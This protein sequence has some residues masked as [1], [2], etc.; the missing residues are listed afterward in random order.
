[1]NIGQY[2]NS[3][4]GVE[5]GVVHEVQ[6]SIRVGTQKLPRGSRREPRH[7]PQHHNTTPRNSLEGVEGSSI[8][9]HARRGSGVSARNSLEG[10]EGFSDIL[11][12][13]LGKIP[14][15]PETP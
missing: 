15:R 4:E 3:L 12:P 8:K 7:E 6:W 5:G 2:R 11:C 14:R 10:V 13:A 9:T 1:M